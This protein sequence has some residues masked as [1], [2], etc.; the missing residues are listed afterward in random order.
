M[1][2]LIFSILLAI[3]LLVFAYSSWRIFSVLRY[4]KPAYPIKDLGQRFRLTLMNA[5]FQ[6]RIFRNRIAGFMHA[7][8]FWGFCIILIGSI[9]MVLDGVLGTDRILAVL[10]P[11]Y[12]VLMAAGDISAYL[13]AA[14]IVVFIIRRCCLDI[15]RLHGKELSA[16]NHADAYFALSMILILMLTLGMLNT[17]YVAG[18]PDSYVGSYPISALIAAPYSTLAVETIRLFHDLSWWI[19][20]LLIFAFANILPYSKHFHIFMSVPNVFLSRLSP[21]GKMRTME[22][23]TREVKLMMNPETAFAAT[24]PAETPVSRFGILDVEDV[25][26]KNY[27]DSLACTQCGRCSAVCPAN[28]TG[29]ELSP[30]KMIIDIR[31]RMNEKRPHLNKNAG[32]YTDNKSLIRDYIK[33]EEI[34]ACTTCNACARECPLNIDQPTFIL[35]LRRY[36]VM[37]ES[38]A[39][40]QINAIF[41]NIENN[42]AP[43]QVSQH[44]RLK[45]AE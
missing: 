44:D 29:K 10:G 22:D 19:H 23:I 2:Q 21:L 25:S 30:R 36:L 37:E 16:R 40:A 15:A 33:E 17:F 3:T 9:E 20:I 8:V 38:S 14:F 24:D 18:H 45:W 32:V 7:L 1:V 28:I 5:I 6:D 13:I 27:L 35:D 4:L 31:R 26:W 34:W 43:W 41:A 11:V 12:N 42:G 39:P